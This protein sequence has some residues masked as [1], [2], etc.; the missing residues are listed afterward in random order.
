MEIV[1][2]YDLSD[3]SVRAALQKAGWTIERIVF[4]F[5]RPKYCDRL[6]FSRN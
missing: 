6:Q 4:S 2:A 3:N 1:N 5:Y